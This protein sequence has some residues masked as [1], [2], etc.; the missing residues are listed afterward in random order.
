M[1]LFIG[2]PQIAQL[3][4]FQ[5][6]NVTYEIDSIEIENRIMY[7]KISTE[8]EPENSPHFWYIDINNR[9][10]SF[11]KGNINYINGRTVYTYQFENFDQIPNNFKLVPLTARF[12]K[13]IDPIQLNLH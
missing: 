8:G 5:F 4:P 13:R 3:Q 6:N 7:L 11:N 1:L 12:K 2:T 9:L 10:L